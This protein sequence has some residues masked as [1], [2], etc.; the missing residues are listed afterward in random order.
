ML[1]KYSYHGFS[2]LNVI[3][4]PTVPTACRSRR[5][6]DPYRLSSLY[7]WTAPQ[8][9]AWPTLRVSEAHVLSYHQF[10][11]SNKEVI[12]RVSHLEL[13][14][15]LG[16]CHSSVDRTA[17]KRGVPRHHLGCSDYS[18]SDICLPSTHQSMSCQNLT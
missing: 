7:V 5:S 10:I 14:L 8:Y 1:L 9:Q 17:D 6:S 4:Y 16:A 15:I 18:T 2:M 13:E 12:I 11:T 3:I